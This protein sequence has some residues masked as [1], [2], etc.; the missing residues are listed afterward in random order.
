MPRASLD[1][2][3]ATRDGGCLLS[4][5]AFA[6]AGGDAT[7]LEQASVEFDAFAA[8]PFGGTVFVAHIASVYANFA[9]DMRR[10]VAV[11]KDY[12]SR[13]QY[14]ATMPLLQGPNGARL[15]EEVSDDPG[16]RAIWADPR[17]AQTMAAYRANIAAFRRGR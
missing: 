5:V 15:P 10:A 13:P 2:I 8:Q 1:A 7:L 16:W 14:M 6:G 9:H 12:P 4:R 3:C 11:L 17:L